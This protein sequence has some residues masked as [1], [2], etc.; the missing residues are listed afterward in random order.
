MDRQSAL[1]PE[2]DARRGLYHRVMSHPSSVIDQF[3]ARLE[4]RDL[5][6]KQRLDRQSDQT[7]AVEPDRAIG[8][9]TRL[10]AVQAGHMS[11]ELRR[12]A[13]AERSRIAVALRRVANGSYGTCPKC[14]EDI[15]LARLDARPDAV[16]CL[17]CASNRD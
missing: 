16:L 2:T 9:L 1:A 17:N 12:Q 11:E 15:P 3:K 4:A 7:S 5:E 10:D 14:E 13:G 6:L 8:R